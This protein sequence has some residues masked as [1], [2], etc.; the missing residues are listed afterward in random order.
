MRPVPGSLLLLLAAGLVLA[1]PW[2]F[3]IQ[4]PKSRVYVGEPVPLSVV[5]VRSNRMKNV[6]GEALLPESS[7]GNVTLFH[8]HEEPGETEHRL[9]Y[10]F[11]FT[12]EKPGP[13]TLPLYGK[14]ATFTNED[15]T[16][17][18]SF[19][20]SAWTVSTHAEKVKAGQ[21]SLEVLPVPEPGLPVGTF[22][23]DATLDETTALPGEPVHLD[24]VLKGTGS[25]V[26][27]APPVPDAPG[28]RLF[29]GEPEVH[30]VGNESGFSGT[31][32][33][34]FSL[35]GQK[36]F[37]VE[38][39]VFRYFDPEAGE[40]KSLRTPRFTVDVEEELAPAA[41]SLVDLPEKEEAEEN[42]GTAL[43]IAAGLL[44]FLAGFVT[45]KLVRLPR[46]RKKA[47]TPAER[48][49]KIRE[50]RALLRFLAPYAHRREFLELARGLE[51]EPEKFREWRDEAVRLFRRLDG[52]AR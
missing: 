7:E 3:R 17:A 22:T 39:I 48:A 42:G 28:A 21:V 27:L 23:L 5:F 31:L 1:Q 50:P 19:K 2:E 32:E 24:V 37:T 10:L 47:P 44:L 41:R 8:L 6:R 40:V 45:G 20:D 52:E 18:S 4:T 38:P 11:L 51:R 15:L 9:R 49:K 12:P 26:R 36:D 34:K 14:V 46:F 43:P 16:A 25:I 29:P 35:V 33:R 13:L 30:I